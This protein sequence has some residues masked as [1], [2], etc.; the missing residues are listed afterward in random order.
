MQLNKILFP[1]NDLTKEE[2]RNIAKQNDL[3]NASKKDSFD[4]CFITSSFKDYMSYNAKNTPGV[5]VD[6]ES[7]LKIGTHDGLS[8]YTI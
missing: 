1:L 4:V 6:I 7:N 2:V 8:Y 5:I 3:I